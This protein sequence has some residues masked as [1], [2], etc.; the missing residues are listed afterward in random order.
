MFEKY[1]VAKINLLFGLKRDKIETEF[2]KVT[3]VSFAEM[4]KEYMEYLKN[5]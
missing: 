1:G 2:L 5:K 4:E 3:G